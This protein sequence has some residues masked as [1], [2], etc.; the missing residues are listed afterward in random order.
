MILSIIID[1][2]VITLITLVALNYH[3]F[4][5]RYL[6]MYEPFTRWFSRIA[7][8]WPFVWWPLMGILLIG[9]IITVF[10]APYAYPVLGVVGVGFLGWFLPHIGSYVADH[11]GDNPIN[12]MFF[13]KRS[14]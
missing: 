12:R 11:A 9:A 14:K 7:T 4:W 3:K 8:A 6:Q 10:Y 5:R 1:V 2:I 13:L